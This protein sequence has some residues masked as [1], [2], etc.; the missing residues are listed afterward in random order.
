MASSSPDSGPLLPRACD[1]CHAIK[2]RCDWMPNGTQC[3]RCCRLQHVCESIRPKGRPGR[4]PAHPPRITAPVEQSQDTRRDQDGSPSNRV[5]PKEA[6]CADRVASVLRALSDLPDM[7]ADNQRVF[8]R[9]LTRSRI[10]DL[11]SVTSVFRD[12]VSREVIPHTLSGPMFMNGVMACALS[13]TEDAELAG[14]PRLQGTCY[15]Y[16]SW[17]M[18]TLASFSVTNSQ[19]MLDCLTLGALISTFAVRMRLNDVAAICSRVLG[20]IE[21]VYAA[22][23]PH[24]DRLWIFISCM[25]MWEIRGCLFSCSAPTL[26]YKPRTDAHVDRHLGLCATLLPLLHDI[27]YLSH[28]IAHDMKDVADIPDQ[29]DVLEKLVVQWQP[30]VPN[31]FGVRFNGVESAHTLC[32]A[33][34][35]RLAALLVIHRLRYPFGVNDEPAHALSAAILTHLKITYT[36]TKKPVRCVDLAFQVACL[37]LKGIEREEWSPYIVTFAGFSSQFGEHV[38]DTLRSLWAAMDS[39]ETISWSDL[40]ARGSPFLRS[41][42]QC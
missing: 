21:P 26:R 40:V 24:T 16:A 14:N 33:Q 18:A 6:Q 19:T 38:H 36:A 7:P 20:L 5:G 42:M 3:Y 9:F 29:L 4:K 41:P 32:H 37:E 39:S 23:D 15:Q 8:W 28:A 13:W 22:S 34:A 12:E 1:R 25:V 10:L 35:M 11:F 27:C 17:A 31:D 30:L 2:V